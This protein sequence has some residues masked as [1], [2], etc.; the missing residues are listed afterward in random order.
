M[1]YTTDDLL[2]MSTQQLDDLF[3]QSQP[4]DIPNGEAQGTAIIAEGTPFSPVIAQIIN[5]FG[6][7]GKTFDAVSGRLVNRLTFFGLSAIVAKIYVAPSW[8]DG[9]DC[10]VLD[11]S[12]TSLVAHWVRDEIRLLQP[13]LYLGIVYRQR[14]RTI[15]FALQFNGE[16]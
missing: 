5:I 16:Q 14:Q 7:Q 6:W 12:E 15:H 11:Y 3:R 13:G 10:I 1:P 9:N 8:F 4:G 2:K